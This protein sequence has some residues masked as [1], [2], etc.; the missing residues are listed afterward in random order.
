[1]DIVS[2]VL[3]EGEVAFF[4]GH[5]TVRDVAALSLGV[6]VARGGEW[7]GW[8]IPRTHQ[9]VCIQRQWT[10]EE[11]EG[12]VGASILDP[13]TR[14]PEVGYTD[15]L[16]RFTGFTPKHGLLN[17]AACH[18]EL[19]RVI[20]KWSPALIVLLSL[21]SLGV[22][23]PEVNYLEI[24]HKVS[25]MNGAA[26][27]VSMSGKPILGSSVIDTPPDAVWEIQDDGESG[28]KRG[29]LGTLR[30][31]RK[32]MAEIR[33]RYRLTPGFRFVEARE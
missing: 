30:I 21:E 25:R 16:S 14:T 29:W 24:L 27:V 6:S 28:D 1:M 12:L 18:R 2:R 26:V 3:S 20:E 7:I 8:D 13:L 10:E 15:V 17:V 9:V 31:R 5:V 19:L 22:L 11:F 33:R 32:V 23:P 4:C